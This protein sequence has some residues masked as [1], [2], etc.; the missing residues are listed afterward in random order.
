MY[1]ARSASSAAQPFRPPQRRLA[2]GA[3]Y[4]QRKVKYWVKIYFSG[5]MAKD[6][7][8][9]AGRTTHPEFSVTLQPFPSSMLPW[10][11]PVTG[12]E[13]V[14]PS[15]ESK[16]PLLAFRRPH[17][18]VRVKLPK[19]TVPTP[20]MTTLPVVSLVPLP[21]AGMVSTGPSTKRLRNSATRTCCALSRASSAFRSAGPPYRTA[22]AFTS[23]VGGLL[24]C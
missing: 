9:A 24:R 10:S 12:T 22:A 15:P 13:S 1:P 17:L 14:D 11:G 8:R 19:N 18:V 6:P 16:T 21:G 5:T 23:A 7:V 4:W 20:G 2:G 3:P